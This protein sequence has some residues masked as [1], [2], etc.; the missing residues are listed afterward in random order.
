MSKRNM[1]NI[2][3]DLYESDGWVNIPSIASLG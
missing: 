1:K 3:L 2:A